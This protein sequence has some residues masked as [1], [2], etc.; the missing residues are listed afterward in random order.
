VFTFKKEERLLKRSDFDL[1]Y[2]K[3]RKLHSRNFFAAY[4]RGARRRI[5]LTVSSKVGPAHKRNRIKRVVREYFRLNKA[6]FPVA[7]VVI[8]AKPGA[9]ALLNGEIR[10]EVAG[11][12]KKILSS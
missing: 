3:G 5:G 12:M 9:G 11:L 6:D 10:A 8:T 7:D 4:I 2:K 1:V